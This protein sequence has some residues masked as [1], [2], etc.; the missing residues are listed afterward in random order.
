[1]DVA[2]V[3][4]GPYGL[5]V[6]AHLA[7]QGANFKV[8][9]RALQ[10]WRDH[11]PR[12]MLLKSDGFASSLSAPSAGSSLG[13]YCVGRGLD[14]HPLTIPVALQTFVDYGLDFQ[15][16][17]VPD[18]DPRT[19][20]GLEQ[21]SDGYGLTLADGERLPARRVVLA[22]GIT[23]FAYMPPALADLPADLVTH[24]SAHADVSRFCGRDVVV[25]G[26]G[27]SAVD[28]AVYLADAG[29]MV[30]LVT[31]R[32]QVRFGSE[33]G[34]GPRS[35]WNRIRHPSSGLGPGLRSRMYSDAPDLVRLLPAAL[36]HEIV[37]RHLG[38]ASPWRLRR[39][40]ETQVTLVAGSELVG[41]ERQG[42]RVKLRLRGQGGEESCI[43]ADHVIAATGYRPD[44]RR[45]TFMAQPLRERLRTTAN[46]P[47]LNQSFEASER[48]LY[49]VGVAA[50]NS[51]GPLMRFMYGAD[52]TARRVSRHLVRTAR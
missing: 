16:R 6:A 33:P 1:M 38:P 29:A 2:V 41:A 30:R 20:I 26:A 5:S 36:R 32:E 47:V 46:T 15:R 52:F 34:Q 3:G 39:K 8:F 28:L 4:A 14:Y 19:V 21:T 43:D 44:L 9:G 22:V 45:L 18:L 24:S 10:T 48:G 27:A 17:F 31:R 49:F 35:R 40:F 51:F 42:D 11:M 50:A 25:V 12:G 13:D 37:R 7:G 23:H